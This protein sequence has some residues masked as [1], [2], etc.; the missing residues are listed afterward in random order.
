MNSTASS[1]RIV[2]YFK[3]MNPVEPGPFV[4]AVNAQH[5]RH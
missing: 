4:I 5:H 1:L 3:I 2:S